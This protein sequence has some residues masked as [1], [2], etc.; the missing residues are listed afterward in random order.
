MFLDC[1]Y[2]IIFILVDTVSGLY[3]MSLC[4]ACIFVNVLLFAKKWAFRAVLSV[5]VVLLA[6]LGL[7]IVFV[8][9]IV[10]GT[11]EVLNPL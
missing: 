10:F 11:L 3:L 7:L 2:F 9:C 8:L 4:I 5:F 6:L 1:T